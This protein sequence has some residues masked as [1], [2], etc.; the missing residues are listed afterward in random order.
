MAKI[1]AGFVSNSSS[2]SFIIGVKPGT[3]LTVDKMMELFK[4]PSDSPVYNLNKEIAEAFIH[5]ADQVTP[6]EIL[7]DYGYESLEEATSS[8]Y[9]IGKDLAMVVERKM[10]IYRGYAADDNGGVEAM[11]CDMTLNIET[12]DLV[13]KKDGGY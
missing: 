12:D 13:I 5:C 10:D 2:S 8:R 4:I 11:V 9:G 6:E 7:N 3:K 1:R